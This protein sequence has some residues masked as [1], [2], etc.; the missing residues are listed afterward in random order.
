MTVTKHR[1]GSTAT[2][3]RA[4]A[5][6]RLPGVRRARIELLVVVVL[7]AVA[8]GVALAAPDLSTVAAFTMTFILLGQSWNVISGLAGPLALGQ[9]AFFGITDFTVLVLRTHGVNQY[10][11]ILVG[12]AASVLLALVVGLA[13]LRL[14]GF[15]FAIASLMVPLII[16][17]VLLYFGFFQVERPFSPEDVPGDFNFN[18]PF[19]YLVAAGVVVVVA[20]AATMVISGRRIGRYFVAIREN[21]RA[22]EASGV[23][24]FRYKVYAFLIAAVL[25]SVS[26]AF[27]SQLTFVF[28]PL[29]A[30]DPTVSVQALVVSLVGGAGTVVGPVLGGV[31]I[32]PV[33]QLARTY[34]FQLP[35]LDQIAYAV[36]LLVV[37][38]WFPR[39]AYPTV[40]RALRR[41][42]ARRTAERARS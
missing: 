11:G 14:P 23:P 17:V 8:I 34:L 42:A 2:T 36:L 18:D 13:T 20:A 24:T 4:A 1:S 21:P 22:A 41:R 15:F 35:G 27:Y 3:G 38:L 10:L 37:A 33:S 5:V 40:A 16:Q 7:V 26:G 12:I 31:I 25:A 28:D 9:A 19:V 6:S 30:F 39:G 32:I 29:D